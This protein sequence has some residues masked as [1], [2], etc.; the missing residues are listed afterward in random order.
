MRG[1]RQHH[2]DDGGV[3]RS[4]TGTGVLMGYYAAQVKRDSNKACDYLTR[5]R[6]LELIRVVNKL[7]SKHV[8]SCADALS[9]ILDAPGGRA[10]V[11]N[12]Q[13]AGVEVTGASAKAKAVTTPSNGKTTATTDYTLTKTRT[14]WKIAPGSGSTTISLTSTVEP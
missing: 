12:V 9:S 5:A 6:Q 7:P 8:T 1:F 14:G 2:D 13:I 11:R 3:R 10:L 4:E